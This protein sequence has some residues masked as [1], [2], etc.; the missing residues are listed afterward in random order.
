MDYK[1]IIGILLILYGVA[2]VSLSIWELRPNDTNS[3]KTFAG[4]FLLIVLLTFGIYSFLH[5]IGMVLHETSFGKFVHNTSVLAIVYTVFG[6]VM[7]ELYSIIAYTDVPISK[8][9]NK[10]NKYKLVGVG[11]GILFLMFLVLKLLWDRFRGRELPSSLD[12]STLTLCVWFILLFCSLLAILLD[13]KAIFKGGGISSE[14]S[15]LAS[16]ILNIDTT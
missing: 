3:D 13:A 5:G 11:G 6:V 9:K 2:K 12:F 4:R 10:V 14:L 8:D 16:L 7:I 15:S 1:I